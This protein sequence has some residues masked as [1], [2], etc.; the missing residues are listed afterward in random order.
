MQ[1]MEV[2][3]CIFKKNEAGNVGGAISIGEIEIAKVNIRE[4]Y[5]S[6]GFAYF[7]RFFTLN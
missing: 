1:T 7:C 4:S 6:D 3:N 2:V 5:F